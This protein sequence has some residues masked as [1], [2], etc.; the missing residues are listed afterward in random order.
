[1]A[2]EETLAT[3]NILNGVT[4]EDGPF[5]MFDIITD[6]PTNLE[7]TC[8]EAYDEHVYF[9]TKSGELLHYFEMEKGNY[10]LVSR[11]KFNEYESSIDK[12]ILLP[13]LERACVLSQNQ[14]VL[15]ILP[16]FAPVPNTKSVNDINDIQ[17]TGKDKLL[18]F[19]K[20]WTAFFKVEET[21]FVKLKHIPQL[22]SIEHGLL[23]AKTLFLAQ[24]N[25]YEIINLSSSESLPLFNVSE[26]S[27]SSL[28][29]IIT[30]FNDNQILICTGG[31]TL[32]ENAMALVVNLEGDITQGTI[33]LERY[34][35]DILVNYP[36]ILV[37]FDNREIYIYKLVKNDEPKLIQKIKCNVDVKISFNK[38]LTSF[39]NSNLTEEQKIQKNKLTNKLTLVPLANETENIDKNIIEFKLEKEKSIIQNLINSK[40]HLILYNNFHLYGLEKST[41]LLN[42]NDFNENEIKVIEEYLESLEN[43]KLNKFEQIESRYLT[44]FRKLLILLHCKIIDESIIEDWCEDMKLLDIRI[45]LYLFNLKFFGEIWCPNGLKDFIIKLKSLKLVNKC[46]NGDKLL[47]FIKI[48]QKCLRDNIDL[49][50]KKNVNFELISKSVDINLFEIL[51]ANSIE[52]LSDRTTDVDIDIEQFNSESLSTIIKIIEDEAFPN[53]EKVLLKVYERKEMWNEIIELFKKR[54]EYQQFLQ[55]LCSH[56]KEQ[57]SESYLNNNLANDLVFII[58]GLINLSSKEK[59]NV[60]DMVKDVMMIID[61]TKIDYHPIFE[62]VEDITFRVS[63]LE[64][65]NVSDS[66]DKEFLLNYYSTRI[67]ETILHGKLWGLLNQFYQEYREDLDY[68]KMNCY[69]YLMTKIKYNENFQSFI[70]HRENILKICL[71][72]YELKKILFESIK[73]FDQN[74]IILVLI[75]FE[76]ACNKD[77]AKRNIDNDKNVTLKCDMIR[78]NEFLKILMQFK[79]FHQVECLLNESNFIEIFNWFTGV[80]EEPYVTE[81][82]S[83]FLVRNSVVY[84]DNHFMIKEIIQNIP[85]RSMLSI[86]MPFMSIILK[87]QM[88]TNQ[89]I[90]IQKVIVKN[91]LNNY[92]EVINKF[93]SK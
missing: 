20:E 17:L 4:I 51:Y 55:F 73:K 65:L 47:D 63:F 21:K 86:L 62:N 74:D 85:S 80:A 91:E 72:D 87:N 6:L 25:T 14:L 83:K 31:K 27:N 53:C 23:K 52:N 79:D 45:L 48:M 59:F 77:Y 69:D 2:D 36:Y 5:S 75:F 84:L 24:N 33:A 8:C 11:V 76:P 39:I 93:Y 49:N 28:K 42:I 19:A 89:Q 12:I 70:V 41:I 88:I 81:L 16:E 44:L 7:Y 10:L 92:N 43:G 35:H 57:L 82:I 56:H 54:K 13:R 38:T 34:P 46:S 30:E 67:Q 71:D 18:I 58:N 22:K 37:N 15:Y 40:T 61:F 9:G 26:D 60:Q 1:M 66:N 64:A 78:S 29:P 90:N 50:I 32:D 68:L 3:Q